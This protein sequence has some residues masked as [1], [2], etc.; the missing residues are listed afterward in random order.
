MLP[1]LCVFVILFS[2]I[3]LYG[4]SGT[5]GSGKTSAESKYEESVRNSEFETPSSV[6][7]SEKP[8]S[9]ESGKSEQSEEES[10]SPAQSEEESEQPAQSEQSAEESE[11]SSEESG[12]SEQTSESTE[13]IHDFYKQVA[14]DKYLATV[15]TC[16]KKAT[17][18]YSCVC[19]EKGSSTFTYGNFAAHKEIIDEAVAPTE[20][21]PGLSEGKHC[22]VCGKILITQK[23]IPATGTVTG[24]VGLAYDKNTV[25]GIGTCKDTNVVIPAYSPDG[26][27]VTAIGDQAFYGCSQLT[28][29]TI[30]NGVTSIGMGAFAVC[31][32]LTNVTIPNS[33][34]AIG[35]AA[36]YGCE[37]L[38]YNEYDNA[39]YLGNNS[40]PYL[41][42]IK[43]K[44]VS[45][46]SCIIEA[47]TKFISFGAFAGCGELTSVTIPDSVI[48]IGYAAFNE[49]SKLTGVTI[50]N[51][52]TSISERTFYN[53]GNLTSATIGS[54]VTS[55]GESAF[56]GCHG[57]T[58]LTISS[59]IL[60]YIEDK[61]FSG[62]SRLTNVNIPDSV[63]SIGSEAFGYCQSLTNIIIPDK[64]T[65]I[66]YQTFA[67]CSK[68]THAIIGNSVTSI[69]ESAFWSCN[70]LTNITIPDSVTNIGNWAFRDCNKLVNATIGSNVTSIGECAFDGC[71]ELVNITIP[72]SVSFIGTLAFHECPKLN[73]NEFDNALYLGNSN[74]PY[75]VLID[76]KNDF[77]S[78]C[79]INKNTKIIYESAFV[80]CSEFT[81]IIIPGNVTYIGKTAFG[82][83]NKL[84]TITVDPRNS[85]YH[86]VGNC[87]IE[88]ASKTLVTGCKNS[89]IPSDG[90]VTSIGREAFYDCDTLT[91]I[92]IPSTITSIGWH[93]FYSCDKL[94]KITYDST[95]QQ[96]K[97]IEKGLSWNYGTGIY[98]VYCTDGTISK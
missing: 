53:C 71:S 95:K 18:Y 87:L 89:I 50:P 52:V 94:V 90:S 65:S 80:C 19:G 24:S 46:S 58:N 39:L 48:S 32:E 22:S 42:L 55:I 81:D 77:I 63:T 23:E 2:A 33:T 69:G 7:N 20:T 15:A 60:T 45:V 91:S 25:T 8:T 51:G 30:P 98:I 49:C 76:A 12:E 35:E 85:K 79:E 3:G 37:K 17:Y 16:T 75:V 62:C 68:L 61:A 92:N 47:H 67:F 84:E 1:V 5:S 96:W 78:S 74:N 10:E 21:T 13:H 88:T 64:V 9:E 86:S 26:Y 11:S 57:L 28:N 4:C 36:F 66:N 56:D 41:V 27:L 54:D 44:D 73:Y 93:A 83:C 82:R 59:N 31:G 40:N 14:A 97:T 43:A 38:N 29:I 70:E 72:D 34:T 6:E